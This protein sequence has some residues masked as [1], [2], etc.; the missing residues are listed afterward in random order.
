MSRHFEHRLLVFS[1]CENTQPTQ[2]D[3]RSMSQSH[4]VL[5]QTVVHKLSVRAMP[6][7]GSKTTKPAWK[8]PPAACQKFARLVVGPCQSYIRDLLAVLCIVSFYRALLCA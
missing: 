7:T 5:A 8:V 4:E 6:S 2:S 1:I 3:H